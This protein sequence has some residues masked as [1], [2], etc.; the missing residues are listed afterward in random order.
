MRRLR[1]FATILGS[2]LLLL[3]AACGS[4]AGTNP[5][6]PGQTT[7]PAATVTPT[8]TGQSSAPPITKLSSSQIAGTCAASV[9]S[10]GGNVYY[11]YGD[12][13]ITQ[14]G[15]V[16]AYP[17]KQI[18]D[19][20]PLK[21]LQLNDDM[22]STTLANSPKTNPDINGEGYG[23]T[24][25]NNSKGQSHTLKSIEASV[26]SF[27]A[28]GGQLN[29]WQPC[30]G[31]YSTTSGTEG[32]GCGGGAFFDERIHATFPANAG[33]GA[34]ATGVVTGTYSE[35]GGTPPP[36]LPL[37]LAPGKS[38]S[39]GFSVTVPTIPGMY[40]FTVAILVDNFSAA[41]LWTSSPALFAPVAHKWN[42]QACEQPNMKSQIPSGGSEAFYICPAS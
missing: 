5:N 33:V 9:D 22:G 30:D 20:T 25:C 3:L 10:Y 16:L 8:A 14:P 1:F 28:Y 24:V 19:G 17:Q 12:L 41:N 13:I 31:A 26:A 23:F 37:T 42:G 39:I 11:Q 34:S 35:N 7:T 38:I 27:S 21:P 2:L 15:E 29:A 4:T 32:G 6:Q 40:A 36:P 18:P